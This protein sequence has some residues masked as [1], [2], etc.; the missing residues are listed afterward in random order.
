[1]KREP[2]Q[3]LKGQKEGE[4]V[5]KGAPIRG[6]KTS[7]HR[8]EAQQFCSLS[9]PQHV[10]SEISIMQGEQTKGPKK[11]G[12]RGGKGRQGCFTPLTRATGGVGCHNGDSPDQDSGR[13]RRL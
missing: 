5:K 9:Q 13:E 10:K 1:M 6:E 11:M 4:G 8:K 7:D 2:E 12:G 3:V